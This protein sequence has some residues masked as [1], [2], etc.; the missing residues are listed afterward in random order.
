MNP[1]M[2]AYIIVISL[3]ATSMNTEPIFWPDVYIL[4]VD[5]IEYIVV[6]KGNG[7]AIY[8]VIHP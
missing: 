1:I 3:L 8:P 2:K 6:Q 5:S 4:N 7:V